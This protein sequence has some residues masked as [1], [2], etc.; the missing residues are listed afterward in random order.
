MITPEEFLER[1]SIEDQ[2]L[3]KKYPA[4]S[5]WSLLKLLQSFVRLNEPEK[6][7]HQFWQRSSD[8]CPLEAAQAEREEKEFEIWIKEQQNK[9]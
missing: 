1:I 7:L 4:G 2:P 5:D 3:K 6:L 9:E 8:A